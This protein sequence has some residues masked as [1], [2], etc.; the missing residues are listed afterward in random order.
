MSETNDQIFLTAVP[1]EQQLKS[2]VLNDYEDDTDIDVKSSAD[3]EDTPLANHEIAE[4]L[5]N[6]QSQD[7]SS[8][9]IPPTVNDN[10]QDKM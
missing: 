1:D 6:K 7:L 5:N 4:I 10:L 8:M 9:L 3:S 2:M